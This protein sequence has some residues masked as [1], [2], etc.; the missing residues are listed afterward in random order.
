MH[1]IQLQCVSS[2]VSPV[3]PERRSPVPRGQGRAAGGT[4][5]LAFPEGTCA[6]AIRSV[7]PATRAV[8]V[9]DGSFPTLH[10]Y[11]AV[12][13]PGGRCEPH[14]FQGKS[15]GRVGFKLWPLNPAWFSHQRATSCEL[16]TDPTSTPRVQ[17]TVLPS[18]ELHVPIKHLSF[19]PKEISPNGHTALFDDLVSGMKPGACL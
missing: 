7:S 14:A 18:T 8:S 16:L 11:C 2:R 6:G 15:K 3:T 4:A 17:R 13:E 10:A 5:T 9:Q 1:R 19:S 12:G